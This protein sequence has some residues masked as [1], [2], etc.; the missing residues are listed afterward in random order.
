M[1]AR[2][3]HHRQVT[4]ALHDQHALLCDVRYV[5]LVSDADCS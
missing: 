3:A 1:V 4:A 2:R 5:D